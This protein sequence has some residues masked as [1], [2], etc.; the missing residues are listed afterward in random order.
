MVLES[1]KVPDAPALYGQV[2][3]AWSKA[4][5]LTVDVREAMGGDHPKPVVLR[6]IHTDDSFFIL[7]QWPDLNGQKLF[8]VEDDTFAESGNVGLW[9]KAD[10]VIHFDNFRVRPLDPMRPA[11]TSE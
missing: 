7:A 4:R 1:V 2:E 3:E 6:A 8:E 9:T 5:P 11:T 10:S